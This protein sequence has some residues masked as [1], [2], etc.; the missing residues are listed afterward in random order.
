QQARIKQAE[1]KVT[2]A[3][4]K[5]ADLASAT[6]LAPA[7]DPVAAAIA[8]AQAKLTMAPDEKLRSTLES[9]RARLTKA[10]EKAAVAEVEGSATVEALQQGVAK[11]Q[12]KIAEAEAELASIAPP[13]TAAIEATPPAGAELDAAKAAIEKAKAKAA[14]LSGMS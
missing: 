7:D 2:E 11:L 14:A 8:R 3:Q 10:Q 12:Q 4:K 13:E 6:A 5:L 9:L 1:L